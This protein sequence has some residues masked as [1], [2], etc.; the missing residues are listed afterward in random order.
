MALGS[1]GVDGTRLQ[2]LR[3][4]HVEDL[5]QLYVKQ[6]YWHHISN[7]IYSLHVSVSHVSNSLNSSNYFYYCH[8]LLR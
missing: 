6:V 1:D 2:I 5:W 7:S 3:F 4:S 8:N